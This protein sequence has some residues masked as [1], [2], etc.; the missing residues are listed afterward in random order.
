MPYYCLYFNISLFKST[1]AYARMHA[2][3]RFIYLPLD[4]TLVLL[5]T[6]PVALFDLLRKKGFRRRMLRL[7]HTQCGVAASAR[8]RFSRSY[9]V[10][11]H[12]PARARHFCRPNVAIRAMSFVS[13]HER[14]SGV[15]LCVEGNISAGKSTFL[16]DIIEGSKIL[17]VRFPYRPVA[18]S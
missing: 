9:R 10:P 16:S 18:F 1:H 3:C 15:T 5:E 14:R 17:K 8:C 6:W 12:Q 4:W 11:A 2:A 13:S 7:F